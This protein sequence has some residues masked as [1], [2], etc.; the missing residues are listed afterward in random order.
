MREASR[1]IRT[2]MHELKRRHLVVKKIE[3]VTS[4][5]KRFTFTGAD[6]KDF[7]SLSPDDHVKVFFDDASGGAPVMRDYTPKRYDTKSL[8]LDLEFYLHAGGVGSTW[9]KNAKVGDS[10]VVGGPRGSKIVPY[11]YDWYLMVGD[12][13]AIPSFAR[14]LLEL[15][16]DARALVI[17]EVENELQ[18]VE[19]KHNGLAEIIWVYRK[20]QEPGSSEL[21]KKILLDKAF[22]VGE[23]FSWIALEKSAAFEIK[24][25][26]LNQKNA[27]SEWIKAAG[28]WHK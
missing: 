5:L 4:H 8:E 10:L 15:P 21:L 25:L 28:Y 3:D 22:P 17:V 23:Y 6:L 1:E 26:L 20:G 27:L 7:V 2:V 19:F 14:R 9:A 12:E 18:K 13:C 24:D 16:K 11:S